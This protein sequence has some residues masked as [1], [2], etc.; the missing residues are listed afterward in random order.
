MSKKNGQVVLALA[1]MLGLLSG[2][3]REMTDEPVEQDEAIV[4]TWVRIVGREQFM[5]LTLSP[6]GSYQIDFTGDT[7]ADVWGQYVTLEG[8][9][10]FTDTGGDYSCPRIEGIYD[11]STGENQLTFSLMEDACKGRASILFGLWVVEDYARAIDGYTGVIAAQADDVKAHFNRGRLRLA[12]QDY[13]GALSDFNKVIELEPHHAE[14]HAER[15]YIK[16][17]FLLDFPGSLSDYD[18]AIELDPDRGLT[19]FRRG[20][21]RNFLKDRQ[22]ACS[23]WKRSLELGFMPAAELIENQCSSEPQER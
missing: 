20:L 22:G 14:A 7:P 3:A 1:L 21:T 11:Y 6:D 2:C 18:R 8:Q 19:Y 4:G 15:G 5:T 13:E 12:T 16:S 23:D 9:I 10:R 17:N